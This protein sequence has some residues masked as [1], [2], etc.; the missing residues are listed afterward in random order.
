M[1]K[2][3]LAMLIDSYADAKASGN[4]YL[5][6]KMIDEL[7]TALTEVCGSGGGDMP[8]FEIPVPP[9]GFPPSAHTPEKVSAS[10]SK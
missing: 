5:V 8:P 4:K 2:T 6:E 1:T 10:V 9:H 7:E 3:E